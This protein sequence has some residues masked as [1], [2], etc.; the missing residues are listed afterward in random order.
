MSIVCLVCLPVQGA[1]AAVDIGFRSDALLAS[2]AMEIEDLE[3]SWENP[4]KGRYAQARV[5]IESYVQLDAQF[6]LGVEQ[7]WHYLIGF[8]QETAQFYSRLE[9]NAI[10][11]GTYELDLKINGAQADGAFLQYFIPLSSS[12]WMKFKSHLLKGQR[13]QQGRLS[14]KGVVDDSS[15]SYDWHLDYA[16]DENRIFDGPRTQLSGWGYSFD[17]YAFNQI[18]ENH[19]LYLS[20]EDVFYTLHWQDVEQ[21]SGCLDRPLTAACRVF[22]T[23]ES[24]TQRFPVFAKL[25]WG[26][27]VQDIKASLEL[28]A[29]QRY[30]AL[31]L[32]LDYDG[33]QL[34]IDGINEMLNLGYESSRLKVK[35]GFDD[36]RFAQAK[37]WQ[38]TLDMN[39]P[40]L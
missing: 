9:N 14:G 39:W 5:N 6:Q 11:N 28:Q 40:I 18:N 15:L 25:K 12:G 7:R 23:R 33:M 17:V 36:I 19:S 31:W 38:L 34:E 10:D 24:Y 30:R 37:H 4:S 32:G 3:S 20:L 22:T 1:I 27:Q 8:S 21:D 35:W 16:Y 29:W 2:P 13:V 26:Y